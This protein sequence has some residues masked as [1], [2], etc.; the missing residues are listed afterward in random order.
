VLPTKQPQIQ[1]PLKKRKV[2]FEHTVHVILIPTAEEYYEANL[3]HDIWY[4]RSELKAIEAEAIIM[5]KAY[6]QNCLE[7]GDP[8]ALERI[9]SAPSQMLFL[10]E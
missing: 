10:L 9:R 2:H 5:V 7:K 1:V 3:W 4:S 8:N 6:I